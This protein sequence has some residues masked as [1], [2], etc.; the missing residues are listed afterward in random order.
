MCVFVCRERAHMNGFILS[1]EGNL[2]IT[3]EQIQ[4]QWEAPAQMKTSHPSERDCLGNVL[5]HREFLANSTEIH[6][7][8]TLAHVTI[9]VS[10]YHSILLEGLELIWW[11][12]VR[13][14]HHKWHTDP[15]QYTNE[16]KHWFS[17]QWR[18]CVCVLRK[19]MEADFCMVWK[20][21]IQMFGV[22]KILFVCFFGGGKNSTFIRQKCIQY[23]KLCFF[24]NFLFVKE[25]WKKNYH[26]FRSTIV[27]NINNKKKCFLSRKLAYYNDFWRIV[28]HWRLE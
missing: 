4:P 13:G 22:S 23:I 20:T 16:Q 1:S 17:V 5:T 9:T 24:I 6:P 19:S 7:V 27:F 14:E 2:S 8:S 11:P 10:N 26:S 25:S 21:Q 18:D 3:P 15:S 28:W 12:Q